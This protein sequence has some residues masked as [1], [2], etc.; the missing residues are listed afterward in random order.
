MMR[1]R[2]LPSYH[3]AEPNAEHLNRSEHTKYGF[4]N[5]NP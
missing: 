5:S 1:E 3:A 4:A 2:V